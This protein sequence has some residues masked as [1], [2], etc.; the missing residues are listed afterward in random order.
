MTQSRTPSIFRRSANDVELGPC[1][2]AH[3]ATSQSTFDVN[4]LYEFDGEGV[5][6]LFAYT[7]CDGGAEPVGSPARASGN[8]TT[9]V[10]A[11]VR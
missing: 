5:P 9:L 10:V 6:S 8:L 2:F 11:Q 1:N 4:G 3:S 7:L